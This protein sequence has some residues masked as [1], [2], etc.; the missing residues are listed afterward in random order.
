MKYVLA[1]DIGTTGVKTCIFKIGSKIDLVAGASAAYPLYT[2]DN[3]GAEQEPDDWWNK[4]CLTTKKVLEESKVDPKLIEGIS[5]CSQAQGLVLVD[6]NGKPVRRAMSYMDQRATEEIKKGMAHGLQI[7]G[8][9]IFKLIPSLVITGAVSS[10]VKDPVWKYKWVEAHEPNLFKKVHKWLDVK[11]YLILRCTGG[12]T[13]TI[14]SAYSTFLFDNRPKKMHWS[15]KLCK[16][17]GVN[18]DHL[19]RVIKSTDCAGTL[20]ETAA[21]EL[22]LVPGIKVF[23][24]GSDASLIGV[25]AG[26]THVGDTHIY[27]GTSG[28]VNTVVDHRLVDTSAMIAAI[29]GAEEKTLNYFAEME[30]AGKCL[31]WAKNHLARDEIVLYLHAHKEFKTYEEKQ[32]ALFRYLNESIKNV[33]PGANGVLFTPWLHGNRCP[34]EDPHACGTF[35]GLSIETGKTEI[36]RSILEGVYYHIRWMLECQ[37]R[38][39]KIKDTIRFV[40]GG[41]IS[42]ISC[43]LVADITG[44]KIETIHSPQNVGAIGAAAIVGVGLGIIP[45]IYAVKKYINVSHTYVPD[46]KKHE[47]FDPHYFAFKEIHKTNKALFKGIKV[48]AYKDKDKARTE[49]KRAVKFFLFSASAGIVQ[50]VTYT[51][52]SMIVANV[53][54]IGEKELASSVWDSLP[55][56]VSLVLSVLWNFTFNRKFTFKSASNVPKAMGL[57]FLFYLFFTPASLFLNAFLNTGNVFGLEIYC[58][59]KGYD[60]EFLALFVNMILNFVL[61][62]FWQ[63]YVVFKDSIDTNKK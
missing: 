42:P 13:M 39:I 43:Q 28:W 41:A 56:L 17:M 47:Q 37:A 27:C 18:M 20:N 16:M 49:R 11:D 29:S 4:M 55:Y 15:K 21:K 60:T 1:Y 24:G 6:K 46:A 50:L 44:K 51:A 33:P 2:F 22:G 14:D 8:A 30:T 59:L 25:G 52:L 3:G 57:T 5:F 7:A 38:K 53:L 26:S 54:K 62:F 63:R 61:E 36:I 32:S 19:P 34:F 48:H 10:S 23:G 58:P 9:N 12:Y 35:F 45:S 31:D 40:G